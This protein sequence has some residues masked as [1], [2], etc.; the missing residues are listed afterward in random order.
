[1]RRQK[2]WEKDE[3]TRLVHDIRSLVLDAE[4]AHVYQRSETVKDIEELKKRTEKELTALLERLRGEDKAAYAAKRKFAEF[5]E[6]ILEV[7]KVVEKYVAEISETRTHL[8]TLSVSKGA[9]EVHRAQAK[10]SDLST[11]LQKWTELKRDFNLALTKQD[12]AF[13]KIKSNRDNTFRIYHC[14]KG[15]FD[16]G[17]GHS[18]EEAIEIVAD[19]DEQEAQNRRQRIK[20]EEREKH[21]LAS[22]H[23]NVSKQLR[24]GETRK[25][26]EM[27]EHV[28]GMNLSIDPLAYDIRGESKYEGSSGS[29]GAMIGTLATWARIRDKAAG[30]NYDFDFKDYLSKDSRK[31]TVALKEQAKNSP[32]LNPRPTDRKLFHEKS[33]QREKGSIK[34]ILQTLQKAL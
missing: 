28:L 6:E 21:R 5:H 10:I 8:A 7:E 15:V 26:Q 34:T 3:K 4:I 1:V 27:K 23:K 17:I 25:K 32:L 2:Q 29:P 12:M 30:R 24:P 9:A 20:E 33:M 22:S 13:R 14:K 18:F 31:N 11:E 16:E 19:A